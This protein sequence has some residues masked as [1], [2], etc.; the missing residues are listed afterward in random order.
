[1][2]RLEAKNQPMESGAAIILCSAA[3]P[4]RIFAKF[5]AAFKNSKK[6]A[7]FTLPKDT[8]VVHRTASF[9][10]LDAAVSADGSG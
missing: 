3:G 4:F 5:A 1:L 8:V 2:E 9:E 10:A 7:R 6:T